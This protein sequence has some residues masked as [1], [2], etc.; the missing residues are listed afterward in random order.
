M[1]G[2]KRRRRDIALP[3]MSRGRRVLEL[4]KDV[5]IAAL[6]CS[7]AVLA[8]RNQ[9]YTA[10]GDT[11]VLSGLGALFGGEPT[12]APGNSDWS[13][14]LDAAQPV[15]LA[16]TRQAADTVLRYGVQYDAEQTDRDIAA[17]SGFLGEALASARTP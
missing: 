13:S 12:A 10:A 1:A 2:S 6:I 4:A 15:R 11:G 14:P 7:A 16:V 8:V 9:V 3:K 5:L 17:L